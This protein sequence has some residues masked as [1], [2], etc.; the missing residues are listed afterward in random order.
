M[1]EYCVVI[2]YDIPEDL[3]TYTKGAFFYSD[4]TK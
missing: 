4:S 3:L 1:C 2:Y